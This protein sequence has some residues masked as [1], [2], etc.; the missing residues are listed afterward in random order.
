MCANGWLP[1]VSFVYSSII[2]VMNT[3]MLTHHFARLE[4]MMAEEKGIDLSYEDAIKL[5]QSQK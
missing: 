3:D 5:V 2:K 4:M 1:E